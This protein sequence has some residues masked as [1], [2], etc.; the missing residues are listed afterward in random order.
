MTEAAHPIPCPLLPVP[1][2]SPAP[3]SE[4]RTGSKMPLDLLHV[5]AALED[6]R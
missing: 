2:N 4:R 1:P 6:I 3:S 5:R